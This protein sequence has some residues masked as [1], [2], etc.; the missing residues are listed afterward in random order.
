MHIFNNV[1]KLSHERNM[2]DSFEN[3]VEFEY[4]IW[5][6][7]NFGNGKDQNHGTMANGEES[8]K[9][10]NLRMLS[11]GQGAGWESAWSSRSSWPWNPP[12]SP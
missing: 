11:E 12:S 7:K 1:S 6:P 8:V 3:L 4:L 9:W 2:E 10:L 5:K